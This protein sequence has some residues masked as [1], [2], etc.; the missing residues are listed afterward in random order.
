MLNS[1]LKLIN[2]EYFIEQRVVKNVILF[3]A[4]TEIISS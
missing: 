2:F 3:Y 1:E 4:E